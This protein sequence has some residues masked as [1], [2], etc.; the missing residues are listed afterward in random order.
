MTIKKLRRNQHELAEEIRQFCR[1]QVDLWNQLPWLVLQAQGRTGW[2]PGYEYSVGMMV[3]ESLNAHGYHI[4][5]VD[6]ETGELIYAPKSQS[7]IRPI[8]DDAQI[9]HIDLEELDA[10][11]ILKQ[12]IELSQEETGSYYNYEEQE[13]QRQALAKRY[14]LAAGKPYRRKT[15]FK[16]V[17]DYLG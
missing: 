16:V 15:P 9:L 5:G 11:P 2:G 14:H 8:T 13:K 12:Y 7:D 4:G 10:K 17:E 6:L 3:L 1:S